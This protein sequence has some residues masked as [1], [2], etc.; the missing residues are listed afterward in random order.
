MTYAEETERLARQAE[1]HCGPG[2]ARKIREKREREEPA[3]YKITF[4]DGTSK[5]VVVTP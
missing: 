3:A 5:T 4:N 1:K 2:F